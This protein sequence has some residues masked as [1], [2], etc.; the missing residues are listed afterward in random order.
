M[1]IEHSTAHI[2]IDNIERRQKK[3]I[4]MTNGCFD[5]IHAGHVHLLRE[6]KKLGDV[7]VVAI[8]SDAS[9]TRLKGSSRP[10]VRLIDRL[11][12]LDAIEFVDYVVTFVG[13]DPNAVICEIMPDILVKGEDYAD[14][15]ISGSECVMDNGG[16]I[17]II[18][19]L[20][21]RSTTGII[22]TAINLK[23]SS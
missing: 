19:F 21:G 6:A 12:V 5:I 8:N 17:E 11:A 18:K 14:K 2:I 20:E 23:K 4:V 10:V 3:T 1:I 7:L 9:V 15:V 16:R 22:N 13:D